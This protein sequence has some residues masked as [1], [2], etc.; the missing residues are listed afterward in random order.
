[1]LDLAAR[2]AR[3]KRAPATLAPSI[4]PAIRQTGACAWKARGARAE[5]ARKS[6][7][8]AIEPAG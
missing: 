2:R 3:G 1:V 8:D 7:V 6:A 5:T 4:V